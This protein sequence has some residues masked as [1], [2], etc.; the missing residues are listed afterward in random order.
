MK[1]SFGLI[2]LLTVS[3]VSGQGINYFRGPPFFIPPNT[4]PVSLNMNQDGISDVSFSAGMLE[5]MDYPSSA[6]SLNCVV[7]PD[8]GA[9]LLATNSYAQILATGRQ[10]GDS[11]SWNSSDLLLTTITWNLRNGTSSGWSGPLG[12]VGAGYL[13]IQFLAD[14]GTHYGW[15]HVSLTNTAALPLSP[16]IVD[17]AYETSSNTSIQ[18]G[19]ISEPVS[20]TANLT[21]A[22]EVPPNKG[23]NS[24][25]GMFTLGSY[26]GGCELSYHLELEGS[27]Q[28]TDAGIFGPANPNSISLHEIAD[29]GN[30]VI[31]NLPPPGLIP[32][33]PVPFGPAMTDLNPPHKISQ[34]P[35]VLVYD[36]QIPLSS[37]QVTELQ[38]GEFYVNL[39]S[40]KFRQ[41]ELRGE[42]LPTTPI[43]FSTT[44]SGRNE[45]P[46]N[47]G[48]GRGEAEF[49]LSGAALS[50]AVALDTNLAWTSV[51]IYDSPVPLPKNLVAILD[52][53]LGVQ[54]SKGAFP[55]SSLLGFPGQVLYSGQL[56]LT[57]EQVS[58]LKS[59]KLYLLVLAPRFPFGE[60]GGQIV[61]GQFSQLNR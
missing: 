32:N 57:D 43:A 44:L 17:W 46:R 59:R 47:R 22:N 55:G 53:A 29:L 40:A 3:A 16:Q 1:T 8:N 48:S 25:T 49:F 42:I 52:L 58:Q 34:P 12:A 2:A 26:L 19:Q 10:I 30:A 14:D 37:N 9:Q 7:S 20:F 4:D 56:I 18:A 6:A 51:G 61:P 13:G 54:V 41:G 11:P 21:G 15:I 24:G 60:I 5:T 35:V 39:K 38:R 36:G 31:S 50:W 33:K 23:S 27:F 28:P 45:I